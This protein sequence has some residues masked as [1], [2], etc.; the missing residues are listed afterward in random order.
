MVGTREGG[1]VMGSGV[2]DAAV[3]SAVVGAAVVGALVGSTTVIGEKL[4]MGVAVIGSGVAGAA[5]GSGVVGAAVLGAPVGGSPGVGEEIGADM[6]VAV[7]RSGDVVITG[8]GDV[9]EELL[10]ADGGRLTSITS[11]TT[12]PTRQH[13]SKILPTKI[14]RYTGRRYHCVGTR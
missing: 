9:N 6:G 8:V 10:A 1:A 14:N 2:G 7:I 5:V 11:A 3:A 4:D 12:A 13:T